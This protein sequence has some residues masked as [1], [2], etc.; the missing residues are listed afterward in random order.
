[1][2]VCIL[3]YLS[4]T[5]GVFTVIQR[6]HDGSVDFDQSWEKYEDGFG[7]FSSELNQGCCAHKLE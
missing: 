2:T 4:S 5:E 7:D 1:M 3:V 6:R